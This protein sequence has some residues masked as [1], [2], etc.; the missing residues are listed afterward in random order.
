MTALADSEIIRGYVEGHREAYEIVDRWIRL[1]VL[2]PLW[3]LGDR[4]EDALQE[5]R[6][7][8][9]ENL[10]HGKFRGLSSLRTYIAQTAKFVCIEMLRTKIRHQAD[11]IDA[12]EL[13]DNADGPEKLLLDDERVLL[14]KTALARL[15]ERCRLLFEMIFREE[16]RYDIIAERL[17]VAEGTVKSRASRCRAMLTRELRPE[18]A[19]VA[20]R[21]D[22]PGS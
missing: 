16:L 17:G 14:L 2:S 5:T 20:P 11:D 1:V 13:G 3:G 22:G 12:M 8:V 9:Y 21:P 19:I 10:V 6:R 7:R 18:T 4:R 15:P